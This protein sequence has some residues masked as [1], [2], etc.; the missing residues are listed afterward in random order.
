M[1][2][3]SKSTPKENL[4]S[5]D[6]AEVSE[7]IRDLIEIDRL[8]IIEVDKSSYL[9]KLGSR[10]YEVR[11]GE[12]SAFI[13]EGNNIEQDDLVPDE[14]KEIMM[15]HEIR[16]KEYYEAGFKDAHERAANDEVLYVLKFFPPELQKKY[17][18][19]AKISRKS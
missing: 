15:F 16:E 9:V 11:R 3:K 10:E 7:Q 4:D 8:R 1:R 13:R 17:F 12:V 19:F 5:Q 2:E 6:L 14:F 18:E